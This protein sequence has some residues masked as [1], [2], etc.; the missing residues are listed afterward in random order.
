MQKTRGKRAYVIV[1]K[2]TFTELAT[3]FQEIRVVSVNSQFTILT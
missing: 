3:I 1:N 2:W